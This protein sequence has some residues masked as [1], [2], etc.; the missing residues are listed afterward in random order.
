MKTNQSFLMKAVTFVPRWAWN[1][2]FKTLILLGFI[3]AA[4][5]AWVIYTTYIKPLLGMAK[6]MKGG[7]SPAT[8]KG[9]IEPKAE[10]LEE[11]DSEYYDE[12]DREEYTPNR[13]GRVNTEENADPQSQPPKAS[14]TDGNRNK[15]KSIKQLHK[16]ALTGKD[17]ISRIMT[18]QSTLQTTRYS[19]E[20]QSA[21]ITNQIAGKDMLGLNQLKESSAD[22]SLQMS[23]KIHKFQEL[24]N[25]VF[26]AVFAQIYCVRIANMVSIIT[27]I[28]NGKRYYKNKMALK[29]SAETDPENEDVLQSLMKGTQPGQSLMPGAQAGANA[30]W[31]AQLN[32]ILSSMNFESKQI[33]ELL[34]PKSQ[35]DQTKQMQKCESFSRE[36]FTNV[37]RTLLF[38][39]IYPL[40]QTK[41]AHLTSQLKLKQN[42]QK[43]QLEVVFRHLNKEILGHLFKRDEQ[44]V[45]DYQVQRARDDVSNDSLDPDDNTGAQQ[46]R[47]PQPWLIEKILE[48]LQEQKPVLIRRQEAEPGEET[49]AERHS[50]LIQ[51]LLDELMDIVEGEYF[52][53]TLYES[54]GNTFQSCILDNL[55]EGIYLDES[56]IDEDKDDQDSSEPKEIND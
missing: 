32:Q 13:S 19:L 30:E 8:D 49:S 36:V 46:V 9:A 1:N 14:S 28:Q 18:F 54:L 12:T 24:K 29:Y 7:A 20:K 25:G 43:S 16:M 3:W 6:M 5:K 22:N 34:K 11:T 44:K 35:E 39:H 23:E 31:D 47:E 45:K 21:Y 51:H 27:L 53:S 40:I 26:T 48:H 50:L 10:D 2:K 41:V 38:E 17:E 42:L 33:E 56:E 37:I 52:Q 55:V 15:K 4:R